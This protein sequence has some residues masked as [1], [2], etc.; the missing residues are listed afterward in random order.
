MKKLFTSRRLVVGVI[1]IIVTIGMITL[2]SRARVKQENP[3]LPVRIVTD[4]S[5]WMSEVVNTPL[6]VVGNAANATTDLFKTYQENERLNQRVDDLAAT[7][8]ELQTV[9]KENEALKNQLELGKTLTDYQVVNATVVSRSPNN[10][11]SE[12]I[13]NQ[14]AKAGIKKDMAVMGGGSLIGRVSEVDTT[15]AK[16][17]LLSDNSQTNN[18]FAIRITNKDNETVDGIITKFNQTKNV[19]EMKNVTSNTKIKKGDKVATS[20]LGGV[21]PS[22]LYIGEVD[23]IEDDDYGL[24]KTVYIKPAA[25][26]NNVPVVSVAI[27][28][29]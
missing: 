1:L 26:F 28:G 22:G 19:I 6:K 12:L 24:T 27:P 18:R 9:R 8:V 15:N 14:G 13:I 11:Q 23:S 4:I 21:T 25:D 2:S 7:K 3:A 10:W 20:G 17:E 16:V 5:S 29:A